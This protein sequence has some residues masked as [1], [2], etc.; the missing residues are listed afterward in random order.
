MGESERTHRQYTDR[1]G[2]RK[3]TGNGKPIVVQERES[4][5]CYKRRERESTAINAL[6]E[7]IAYVS[8]ALPRSYPPPPLKAHAR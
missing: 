4:N 8:A 3:Q 2:K 7:R 5:G 1:K 6:T